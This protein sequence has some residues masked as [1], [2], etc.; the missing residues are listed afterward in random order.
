MKTNIITLDYEMFL[1]N[2]GDV[3]STLILPTNKLSEIFDKYNIKP[4]L[5]VDVAYLLKLKELSINNNKALDDY[6]LI[7]NQLKNLADKEYDLQLHIHPQWFFSDYIDNMWSMDYDHYS[8]GDLDEKHIDFIFKHGIKLLNN[9]SKKPVIAFRAGGYTLQ[10]C[11]NYHLFFKKYGIKIDSSVISNTISNTQYQKYN[12]H[13]TPSYCFYK[14]DN[15][16]NTEDIEGDHF[17]FPLKALKMNPILYSFLRYF[18]YRYS[19]KKYANGKSIEIV[20]SNFKKIK[21]LLIQLLKKKS[22]MPSIDGV[23]INFIKRIFDKSQSKVF[24]IIGHPKNTSPLSLEQLDLFLSYA[25]QKETKFESLTNYY[26]YELKN[27]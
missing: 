5:F 12:Y 27:N 2:P 1:G 13:N 9:I 25:I 11:T 3:Y 14:F 16:C 23:S 20:N 8:L 19:Y 24:L 4:T 17:E 21:Q 18:K 7:V 10:S 6:N 15:D 26:K 22:I